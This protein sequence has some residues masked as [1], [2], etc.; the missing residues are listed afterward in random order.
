MKMSS[1][2]PPAMGTAGLF[3]VGERGY[4]ALGHGERFA[5]KTGKDA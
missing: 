2:T 5:G 1:S 3:A 4:Q